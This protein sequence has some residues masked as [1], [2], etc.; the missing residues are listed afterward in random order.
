MMLL[1]CFLLLE[2][3][4]DILLFLCSSNKNQFFCNTNFTLIQKQHWL[5]ICYI[6][7]GIPI[8]DGSILLGLCSLYLSISQVC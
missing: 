6:E 1:V 3:R 8:Y 4:K 2:N 7:W 5:D